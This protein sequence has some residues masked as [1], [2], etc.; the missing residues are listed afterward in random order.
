M[1]ATILV[2]RPHE[3]YTN[4]GETLK[5][6]SPDPR[7]VRIA[8]VLSVAMPFKHSELTSDVRHPY[9]DNYVLVR[10]DGGGSP[11]VTVLSWTREAVHRQWARAIHGVCM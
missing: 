1:S 10:Y 4:V 6:Q 3:V 9:S 7:F 11:H 5:G 8:P 2:G